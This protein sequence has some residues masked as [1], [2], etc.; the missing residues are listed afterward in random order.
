MIRLLVVDEEASE[1]AESQTRYYAERAGAHVALH[2]APSP[3][4]P[5]IEYLAGEHPCPHCGVVPE[6]YRKLRDGWLVCFACGRS[7]APA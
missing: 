5:P 2:S 3:I 1:E 4:E 7:S 6:R